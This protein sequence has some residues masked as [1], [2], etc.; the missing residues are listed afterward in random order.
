MNHW[1]RGAA[2]LTTAAFLTTGCTTLQHVPYQPS[3]GQAIA[4]PDVKV[5]ESVVVARKDGTTRKF[6]VTALEDEALVGRD[7]RIPYA[8]I[9][10]LDV[11]RSD[12]HANRMALIV[13]AV[14]VGVAAVAAASGGGGG[15]GGY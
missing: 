9:A 12:A 3:A 13:G 2:L 14:V 7:V 6:T 5:G 1:T 11:R 15:N 10:S 4:K 8:D